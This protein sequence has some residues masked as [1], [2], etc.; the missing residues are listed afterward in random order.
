MRI[1]PKRKKKHFHEATGFLIIQL[2]QRKMNTESK[3]FPWI[4]GIDLLVFLCSCEVEW[5]FRSHRSDAG[6]YD[7]D[8][9][10][11]PIVR[12]RQFKF[13]FRLQRCEKQINAIAGGE[14]SGSLI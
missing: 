9:C 2:T 3:I 8:C 13:G 10:S 14:V 6:I 7:A 5:E 4:N 1:Y 11:R 12:D